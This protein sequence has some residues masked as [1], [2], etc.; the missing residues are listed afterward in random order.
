M[1]GSPSWRDGSKQ[2]IHPKNEEFCSS[3]GNGRRVK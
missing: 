2:G 3:N 1:G